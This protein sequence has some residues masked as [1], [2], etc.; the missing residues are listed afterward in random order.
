MGDCRVKLFSRQPTQ[1]LDIL[2]GKR[3]TGSV[4]RRDEI[5][6]D[7]LV[8]IRKDLLLGPPGVVLLPPKT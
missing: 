1:I 6:P 4:R 5:D 7:L 2:K 8:H 3:I